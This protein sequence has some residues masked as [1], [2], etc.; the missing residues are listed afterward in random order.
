MIANQKTGML[1]PLTEKKSHFEGG[2]LVVND[3]IVILGGRLDGD[4]ISNR[5]DMYDPATNQW[6]TIS[7]MPERRRGGAAAGPRGSEG[8]E[9]LDGV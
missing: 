6:R 1:A 9:R 3:R 8:E 2:T 4:A 7:V 5:V